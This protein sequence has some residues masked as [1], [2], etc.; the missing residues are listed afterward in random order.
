MAETEVIITEQNYLNGDGLDAALA[1]A[2]L[3]CEKALQIDPYL[4]ETYVAQGRIFAADNEHEEAKRCYLKAIELKPKLAAAYAILAIHYVNIEDDYEL[5]FSNAKQALSLNPINRYCTAVLTIASALELGEELRSYA[6]KV[7]KLT[8]RRASLNPHDHDA[9]GLVAFAY[10]HLGDLDQARHWVN[11]VSAFEVDDTY[12]LYNVACLHANLGSIDKSL[13]LLERSLEH[14]QPSP[15]IKW[16]KSGDPDLEPLRKDPRFYE[17][18]AR[19][20]S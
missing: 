3:N 9:V 14:V 12:F 6:A 4:A 17:L 20:E 18:L 5:A 2:L 15:N 11:I 16:I 19:H 13:E 8:K 1:H 10:Y 7:L